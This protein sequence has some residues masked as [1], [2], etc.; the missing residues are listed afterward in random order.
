MQNRNKILF[1]LL[2]I[3]I[4]VLFAIDMMIGSV[5]ISVG[6]VWAAVTGGECDPIKAKIIIKG[7]LFQYLFTLDKYF[8]KVPFSSFI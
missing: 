1:L 8:Q 6:E 7:L 3:L 4:V 2:T 5:G